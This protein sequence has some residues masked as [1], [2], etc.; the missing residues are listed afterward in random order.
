VL[1]NYTYRPIV[2]LTLPLK[3]T[4]IVLLPAP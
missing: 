3:W 4:D 2:R 1:V